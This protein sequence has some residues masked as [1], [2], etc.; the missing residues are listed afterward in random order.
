M[1][2]IIKILNKATEW[3]L[4]GLVGVILGYAW[5]MQSQAQSQQDTQTFYSKN[6]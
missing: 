6:N 5:H 1:E 4:V 2:R 3:F